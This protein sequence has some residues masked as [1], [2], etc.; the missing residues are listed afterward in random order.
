M[1]NSGD[2]GVRKLAFT[3]LLALY[4][5]H[6]QYWRALIPSQSK[7]NLAW[8]S[9]AHFPIEPFLLNYNLI[10][11]LSS[12]VRKK[13]TIWRL[14]FISYKNATE[15]SFLKVFVWPSS[16]GLLDKLISEFRAKRAFFLENWFACFNQ[17]FSILSRVPGATDLFPLWFCSI[18][19]NFPSNFSIAS[20]FTTSFSSLF[21]IRYSI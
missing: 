16:K 7:T 15:D 11:L 13:G 20:V 18:L 21:R 8:I 14:I 3:E 5:A 4:F 10:L 17:T 2:L 19:K 12:V 9:L 1:E 6:R